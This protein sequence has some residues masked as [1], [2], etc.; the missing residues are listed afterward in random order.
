MKGRLLLGALPIIR[1]AVPV[2][3]KGS[4]RLAA[5]VPSSIAGPLRG[6]QRGL[7]TNVANWLLGRQVQPCA[8]RYSI[9]R[10]H[11]S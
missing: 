5:T 11:C 8:Q 1:V 10:T 7:H 2:G 9:T 3:A 6:L 4:D